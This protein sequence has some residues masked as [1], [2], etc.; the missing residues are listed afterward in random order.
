MNTLFNNYKNEFNNVQTKASKSSFY[1][2]LPTKQLKE[3][4]EFG[5]NI[6]KK[7]RIQLSSATSGLHNLVNSNIGNNIINIAVL[8]IL[9]IAIGF[10]SF[11]YKSLKDN[12][13]YAL[14]YLIL[15]LV[16]L[17]I[18]M[19]GVYMVLPKTSQM[20]QIISILSVGVASYLC[21]LFV[22]NMI[23]Y[24][25]SFKTDSPWIIKGSKNGKNS[26]VI[27]QNPN[28]LD[29]VMIYRSENQESGIEFSYS[30]WI[31][32]QDYNYNN[33]DKYKHIFHKGDKTGKH[34]YCP[35]VV[36]KN[37]S[38]TLSIM[39]NLIDNTDTDPIDIENLPINKWVH[40]SLV[41]KQKLLEI[42]INGNLKKNVEMKTI[43]RQ[44]FSD[45]WVNLDGGFEG[46]LSKF[47]YHR[48]ALEFNEV[49][50]MVASGPSSDACSVTGIK[51][52]YLD[53]NWWLDRDS[54]ASI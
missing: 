23:N 32:I 28:N 2:Y 43:P 45:L 22:V 48:R 34:T 38:N 6:Q 11:Y 9:I 42:F 30:F 10:L 20:A 40:I 12:L 21:I 53:T 16:S 41:V 39:F 31:I 54:T 49:E 19:Y 36:L 47:Q 5:K 15:A 33:K 18:S 25:K 13:K 1:D 7:F 4:G 46:F 17:L 50:S 51:P 29:T 24:F 26:L 3:V 27:P 35:K 37:D 8:G 14:K 52:P 44:N